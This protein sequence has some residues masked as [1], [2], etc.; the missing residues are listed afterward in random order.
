MTKYIITEKVKRNE[1]NETK[2][3]ITLV[4]KM[5]MGFSVIV[6]TREREIILKSIKVYN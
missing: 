3:S 4:C 1:E 5:W 6:Q 2:L